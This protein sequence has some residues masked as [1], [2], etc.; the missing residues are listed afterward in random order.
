MLKHCP[1]ELATLEIWQGLRDMLVASTHAWHITTDATL[2]QVCLAAICQH[3]DKVVE[4][5]DAQSHHHN[6]PLTLSFTAA[7]HEGRQ[8]LQC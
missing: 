7:Q 1:V 3:C 8:Y 5:K 4:A 6:A 2:S